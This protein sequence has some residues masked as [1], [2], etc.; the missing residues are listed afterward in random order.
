MQIIDVCTAAAA[1]GN[2]DVKQRVKDYL[3]YLPKVSRF[4]TITLFL[5]EEET[6]KIRSLLEVVNAAPWSM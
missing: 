6:K 4:N 1:E 2:E 3:Y 5:D